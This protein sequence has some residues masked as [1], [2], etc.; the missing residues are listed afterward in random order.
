VEKL[1]EKYYTEGMTR[2][3]AI[4][5]ALR[6]LNVISEEKIKKENVEMIT[7]E[8]GSKYNKV[9]REEIGKSLAK[10]DKDLEADKKTK[11]E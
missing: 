3:D 11:A 6:G 2:T 5:L 10:L 8:V 4:D 1:F 7:I 9:D